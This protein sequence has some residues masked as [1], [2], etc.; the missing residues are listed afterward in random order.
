MF[1]HGENTILSLYSSG[2]FLFRFIFKLCQRAE[3]ASARLPGHERVHGHPPG[4]PVPPGMET[5]VL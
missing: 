5:F 2:M 1:V 4:R 3:R